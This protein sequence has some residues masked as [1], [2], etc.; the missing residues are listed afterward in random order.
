[1]C[2][3]Y[4]VWLLLALVLLTVPACVQLTG[5]RITWSYDAVKDEIQILLF[6]D[7]I[8]DSGTNQNGKGLEQIPKFVQDGDFMLLDWPFHVSR[9]RCKPK[10]RT[11]RP[12]R[13]IATGP[14]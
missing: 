12:A 10:R 3:L 6:Y 7:G 2:R 4:R 14:N 1:M 9:A 8:H 11:K 5:Q 13:C